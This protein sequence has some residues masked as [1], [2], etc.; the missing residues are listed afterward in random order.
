MSLLHN[1]KLN[2]LSNI[3]KVL[4]PIFLVALISGCSGSHYKLTNRSAG[5]KLTS[6]PSWQFEWTSDSSHIDP[7]T[8]GLF[9][10]EKEMISDLNEYRQDYI[11]EVE[12]ILKTKYDFPTYV[13]MHSRGKI[14]ARI[15]IAELMKMNL[16][17]VNT[18]TVPPTI[19][20]SSSKADEKWRSELNQE[21]HKEKTDIKSKIGVDEI[22]LDFYDF[23]MNLI[24]HI[25]L[26]ST[27][28][29]IL[30]KDV[31]KEIGELFDYEPYNSSFR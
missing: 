14:I 29:A 25:A 20:K 16:K 15:D 21:W 31:A 5:A 19:E 12:Q 8:F 18:A 24:G 30:P 13:N 3:L 2:N 1:K 9:T 22:A 6:I 23:E 17:G 28:G 26:K 10:D 11:S 7:I 27:R 4:M